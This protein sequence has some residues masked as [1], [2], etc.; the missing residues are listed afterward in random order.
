M[1]AY[2]SFSKNTGKMNFK[3][4]LNNFSPW[5]HTESEF[6]FG[7]AGKLVKYIVHSSKRKN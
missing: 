3:S 2:R 5:A 6:D 4:I 1:A 7:V